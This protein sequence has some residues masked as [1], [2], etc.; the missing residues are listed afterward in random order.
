[1]AGWRDVLEEVVRDRRS[2][3]VGYAH[4]FTRDRATAED[5]LQEAL[6]R[7][8]AHPRRLDNPRAAEEYVRRA[9]RTVFLDEARKR[10]VWGGRAHLFLAEPLTAG[11]ES[12]VTTGIAVT[13]ALTHLSPR[14]RAC[15]VLRYFDD[16]AVADIATELS[17]S[18]GATKRYLSDGATKL[19]T[20]LDL[21]PDA[22]GE[23]ESTTVRPAER[24][25]R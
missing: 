1:M 25:A 20:L 2:A 14:E 13:E 18:T 9:I 4:L 11:P 22:D 19:R 17:L 6:V 21:P 16:L 15:V 5:L 23:S 3:L 24:S 8:F 7:T 12:A 10:K